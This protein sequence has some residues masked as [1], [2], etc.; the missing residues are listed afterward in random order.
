MTRQFSATSKERQ[1]SL[2]EQFSGLLE[3]ARSQCVPVTQHLLVSVFDHVLTSRE[4]INELDSISS[5][6]QAVHNALLH[7][8]VCKLTESHDCYLVKFKG[9]YKRCP[10]F[11]TFVSDD[12][13]K[14]FLKPS[15]YKV[16]DNLRFVLV[17]PELDLVYFEGAD[18]THH[19]YIQ[20][21]DNAGL[22]E[23]IVRGSGLYLL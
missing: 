17:L 7:A 16:S 21:S 4:A 11:R 12:A 20:S 1:R 19:L 9:R 3:L 14:R 22:V 10:T 23:D 2:S 6:Q 13:K 8:F 15:P 5:S 18:F